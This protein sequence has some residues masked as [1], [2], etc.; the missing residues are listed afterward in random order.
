VSIDV[1][2]LMTMTSRT[3]I[4]SCSMKPIL[5][6]YAK[7]RM[8]LTCSTGGVRKLAILISKQRS[9]ETHHQLRIGI[10]LGFLGNTLA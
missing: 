8:K 4:I 7:Y 10:G 1:K 2:G 3:I 6:N 5:N 9:N